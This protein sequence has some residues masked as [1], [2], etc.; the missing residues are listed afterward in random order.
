M[1]RDILR[2]IGVR[3]ARQKPATG[4][5]LQLQLDSK[6]L[7][8]LLPDKTLQEA[9]A[10]KQAQALDAHLTRQVYQTLNAT[11]GALVDT[12]PRSIR[13]LVQT[14]LGYAPVIAPS[15]VP[16]AGNGL[17]ISGTAPAGCL[18]ALFPGMFYQ[19][20]EIP[21]QLSDLAICRYDGVIVDSSHDVCINASF[22]DHQKELY[23]PFG[24]AHYANHGAPNTLQFLLDIRSNRLPAH[25]SALIPVQEAVTSRIRF[26]NGLADM[27]ARQRVPG[28]ELYTK[29]GKNVLR[30]VALVA[31][32]DI[33]DGEEVLF[34]YRFN[35][36]I[37]L[38]SW[39]TD[40]EP[41][42]TRRRW[43][44][45]PAAMLFR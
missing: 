17:F 24:T 19:P 11:H 28:V 10:Q 26:F 39:Y 27:A 1:L 15:N 37:S 33:A 16:D 43:H 6:R 31:L 7:C 21:Q 18:V 8:A 13:D 3:T 35:P 9:S 25:L 36:Q 20:S 29:E 32:R 42:I 2:R 30:T 41:E 12:S 14:K 4:R 38:P 34:N 5:S 44:S 23:H 45:S 40:P 22:Q